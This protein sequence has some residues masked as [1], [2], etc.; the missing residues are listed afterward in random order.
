MVL[1]LAMLVIT[2]CSDEAGEDGL[3]IFAA[4]SLRAVTAD[5]ERAWLA[6]HPGTPLTVATEASNVLAAQISEGARADVFV[7]ADAERPRQLAEA[8]LTAAEPVPFARNRVALVVPRDDRGIAT[9]GD[10]ARSGI[11][12]IVTGPGTPIGGYTARAIEELAMTMADPD[13]F[14]TAVEANIA[15][16]EDNVR[17]ALAKVELGEGDAAFVYR[18][19][20][21]GS[22][23][24]REIDLPPEAR[25]TAEYAAVQVSDRPAAAEFLDWLG[26]PQARELLEAAGFEVR[27]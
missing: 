22:E 16:R 12:I 5:L 1:A 17:A 4:A 11:R 23:Q 6:D 9:I 19:D 13:A 15:S 20:V 8:G 24:V 14:A 10:L 2:A 26:G 25:V 3:T 27:P 18:T 21:L 7:S